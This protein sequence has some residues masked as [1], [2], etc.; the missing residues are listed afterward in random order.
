MKS[1]DTILSFTILLVF[2]II[3]EVLS[4]VLSLPISGS[5]IGMVLLTTFLLSGTIKL[6][7]VEKASDILIDNL[8]LFFVPP[9]VGILQHFDLISREWIPL[10]IG[11]VG[12]TI[13]V[14]LVTA[15]VTNMLSKQG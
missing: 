1:K 7:N 12:S 15:F 10:V 13:A 3:G 6:K 8:A 4:S 5:V 11:T 14:I 2:W 9:G